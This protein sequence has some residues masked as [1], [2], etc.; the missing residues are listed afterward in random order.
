MRVHTLIIGAGPGGL[1]CGKILAENGKDTLILERKPTVGPKVCAG[2]ITWSGL[3]SRVP[4]HLA[5]KTFPVQHVY[6]PLQHVCIKENEPII[7][8]VNRLKFGQYM[9]EQATQAGARLQTNTAVIQIRDRKALLYDKGN[10]EKKWVSF[11][12]LVGAD[13]ST[14]LVR[15]HLGLQSKRLGIGI[16][17]QIPGHNEKMEWHLNNSLFKN[18]Y[19]WI[20]P[21]SDTLSVGAYADRQSLK[22]VQLKTNLVAWAKTKNLQLE[23]H[24]AQA[25]II[26]F[27][28]QGWNFTD[29]FLIGDAAGLAS[30]LTGEGIY[31]AIISGEQAALT[32]CNLQHDS[33]VMDTLIEKHDKHSRMVA[34]SGKNGILNSILAEVMTLG[35]RSGIIKFSKMEMAI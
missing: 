15:R 13:G 27:D 1:A 3:I 10:G 17:Y 19:A 6:T 11:Q 4:E 22:A 31:P 5:E 2:G 28:Y 23:Q 32:I 29:T 8:T 26:N 35:L 34:V 14:S 21:H 33:T 12:Y 9:A 25:E 7:A 18:G 16:N 30:G 24:K 20:F